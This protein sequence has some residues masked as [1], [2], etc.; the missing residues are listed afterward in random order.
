MIGIIDSGVGGLSVVK[1]LFTQN[2]TQ[3]FVYLGDNQNVPYGTRSQDD[4][5]CLTIRMI[6]YLVEH[7]QIDHLIIAC[8]TICAA[9]LPKLYSA[10]PCVRIESI[11]NYGAS[12]ALLSYNDRVTVIATKFTVES[13][14]YL[15]AIRSMDE[16]VYVQQIIA[17]EWVSLVEHNCTIKTHDIVAV[18]EQ[19]DRQNHVVILGC[20]HFPFLYDIIRQALQ[21]HVTIFDPSVSCVAQLSTTISVKSNAL[22]L[23]TGAI[24]PIHT[25]LQRCQ[26]A[27]F[28]TPVYQI[29]L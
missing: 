15:K 26:L 4:I 18:T 13:G 29:K 9:T 14:A 2:K 8:N 22:I 5:W 12:G 27:E 1:E 23:T 19:I 25:F 10:Y 17:Q 11:L 16:S 6:D 7:Y 3:P 20:T 28:N 21:D 24:A